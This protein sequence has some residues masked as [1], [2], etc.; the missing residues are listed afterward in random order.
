MLRYAPFLDSLTAQAPSM[1]DLVVDWV[2]VPSGSHD[3]PGLARMAGKLK[4]AFS[5][6]GGT[7]EEIP[8][9]QQTAV[10]SQ[11]SLC[12]LPLGKALRFRKRPDAPLQVFLGI[13]Y[14][15]VYGEHAHPVGA[16]GDADGVGV[17][18]QQG[19]QGSA[20]AERAPEVTHPIRLENGVLHASGAAD[21][22]GGLVILLK[23]LEAFEASP[24]AAELGWEVL[25]NPDEELG[26][27]GSLPLLKEAAARNHLGLLFE[28]SLPDGHLVGA[29]K[30]SGNFTAVIRGRAA[31]AGRDPHLGR[32]AIHALAEFI[33][34]LDRFGKNL[35]GLNVNVGKVEGGGPVNRVPDL[36]IAR[37]NLRAG[38]SVDQAAAEDWLRARAA[39]FAQ[40]E[41]YA[42]EIHGGFTAPPKPLGGGTLDL[43]QAVV[44]GGREL[45]L[46]LK[47][48]ASG[49]V[50]DGN[51]LAAAGLPNV[52]TLGARG[53]DIHS[54]KEFLILDSLAERARLTALLLMKLGSG[55]LAWPAAR[56][57]EGA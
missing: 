4:S 9:A 12:G 50:S 48:R 27:P 53:G 5:A 20:A 28:P 55:E 30:G 33:V 40:R 18:G 2:K 15:V 6:L 34:D 38:D 42:L 3:I 56:P 47:W 14:D 1:A 26:S 52:D 21:A 54:P 23:A 36:A 46:D 13:H 41:G 24:F 25:L 44:A 57:S 39:A 51:K 10:D 8:L 17:Q 37:F 32:N 22:K 35:P 43:L 31:H 29:R 19:S 49:G 16:Y 45:G 7:G 11:G